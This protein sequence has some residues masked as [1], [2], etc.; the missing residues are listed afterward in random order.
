MI[1]VPR[2]APH[3]L[4]CLGQRKAS[5]MEIWIEDSDEEDILRLQDEYGRK[6]R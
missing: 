5:D 3:R 2:K 4:R 1:F 6:E